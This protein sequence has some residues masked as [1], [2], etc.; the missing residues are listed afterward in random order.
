MKKWIAAFVSLLVVVVT[1]GSCTGEPAP[2]GNGAE[3][4]EPFQLKIGQ[5]ALLESENLRV[6]FLE[7]TEDSR[8]PSDANC[9]TAGRVSI[10]ISV[11]VSGET[12]EEFTL[13]ISAGNEEPAEVAHN[14]FVIRLLLVEPYPSTTRPIDPSDYISTFIITGS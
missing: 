2:A 7:V 12:P 1:L 4:K 5:T 8:C 14:G 3:L 9:I 10:L 13:T 6:T 11:A